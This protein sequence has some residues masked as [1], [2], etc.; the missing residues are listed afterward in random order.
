MLTMCPA[1]GTVTFRALA[2]R[3][4]QDVGHLVEAGNVELAW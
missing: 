3:L 1:P 4:G 2:I